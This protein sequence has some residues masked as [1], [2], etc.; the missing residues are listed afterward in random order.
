M[1][2]FAVEVAN[3]ISVVTAYKTTRLQKYWV[4]Q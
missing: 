4:E 3:G 2:R 1:L